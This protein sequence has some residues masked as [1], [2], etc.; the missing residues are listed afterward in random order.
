[1][2]DSGSERFEEGMRILGRL[3]DPPTVEGFL[4]TFAAHAPDLGRYI[5]E[6]VCGDLMR[7]PDLTPRDLEVVT[8]T[9]LAAQGGA[10]AVL[11]LHVKAALRLGISSREIMAVFIHVAAYAGFPRAVAAVAVANLVFDDNPDLV[12]AANSRSDDPA[13]PPAP[14]DSG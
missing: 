7:R 9:A 1:M 10:E 11:A 6:F 3:G 4:A 5:V 14:T 13:R 12:A 2:T 8:L